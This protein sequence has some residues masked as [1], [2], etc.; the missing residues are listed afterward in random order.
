MIEVNGGSGRPKSMRPTVQRGSRFPRGQ[1]GGQQVQRIDSADLSRRFPA[2]ALCPLSP[3]TLA[4][5]LARDYLTSV[6]EK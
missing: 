1:L 6:V 4:V 3:A 2:Q 5:F